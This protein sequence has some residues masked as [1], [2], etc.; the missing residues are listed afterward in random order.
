MTTRKTSLFLE[1]FWTCCLL[2]ALQNFRWHFPLGVKTAAIVKPIGVCIWLMVVRVGINW[3]FAAAV[4]HLWGYGYAS[5]AV[6]LG[7][8]PFPWSRMVEHNVNLSSLLSPSCGPAS[9]LGPFNVEV[10]GGAAWTSAITTAMG[11]N[12][13]THHSKIMFALAL[14]TPSLLCSVY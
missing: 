6:R 9:P 8:G 3:I 11:T 13:V 4:G 1:F 10:G 12:A 2:C 14:M 7:T 5:S